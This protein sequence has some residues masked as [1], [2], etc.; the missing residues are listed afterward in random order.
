MRIACP[1]SA[2]VCTQH[3]EIH[4]LLETR[5]NPVEPIRIALAAHSRIPRGACVRRPGAPFL[6]FPQAPRQNAARRA[7]PRDQRAFRNSSLTTDASLGGAASPRS[8]APYIATQRVR[9]GVIAE[10]RRQGIGTAAYSRVGKRAAIRA[11]SKKPGF[12]LERDAARSRSKAFTRAADAGAAIFRA[13]TWD[14]R[15]VFS[16]RRTGAPPLRGRDRPL[17][18]PAR[19]RRTRH[20]VSI[21]RRRFWR[22]RAH[23]KRSDGA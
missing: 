2:G 8:T 10:C 4:W 21:W 17:P 16:F 19:R 14:L 13:A 9:P 5:K 3:I 6:S 20:R 15:A 12:V 7:A 22:G 11:L 23:R 18:P 1:L